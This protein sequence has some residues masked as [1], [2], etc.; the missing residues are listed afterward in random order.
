MS[1]RAIK[2]TKLSN[3]STI[4]FD[5]DIGDWDISKHYLRYEMSLLDRNEE[6]ELRINSM[7]GDPLTALKMYTMLKSHP[8][9]VT[10]YI[11]GM[12][13]SAVTLVACAC[14]E[15][16]MSNLGWYMIHRVSLDP[17]RF[18]DVD[19]MDSFGKVMRE[20]ENKIVAIYQD[21]IG[22]SEEEIRA[23]LKPA[24]WMTA[25]EA[26]Q[27]GFVDRIDEVI[28][29]LKNKID[30][31]KMSAH[32][33]G[34]PKELKNNT[35]QSQAD[36]T[37]KKP[38]NTMSVINKL[39]NMVGLSN[40]ADETDVAI[41]TKE[42]KAKADTV[43]AVTAERDDLKSQLEEAQSKIA[44][45]EQSQTSIAEEAEAQA[46]QE[47]EDVLENAVKEFK[48]KASA[49]ETFKEQYKGNIDGLKNMLEGIEGGKPG[50]TFRKPKTKN[51]ATGQKYKLNPAVKA[52]FNSNQ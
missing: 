51:S 32:F 26:L 43:D 42:L 34:M 46:E 27:N 52:H 44:E 12:C 22:K 11:E 24:T 16:V 47:L 2:F 15:V 29:V 7:G 9:K 8:G 20:T 1:D 25:E 30:M 41:A 14:D 36:S 38:T 13:G 28:P 10:G 5:G 45:L 17:T 6:I 18:D 50:E 21:Q 40:D 19:E 37:I 31:I 33:E 48:I 3:K 39:K 23:M 49:K 4:L 35:G